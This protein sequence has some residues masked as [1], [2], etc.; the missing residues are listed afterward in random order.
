VPCG[1]QTSRHAGFGILRRDTAG[2]ARRRAGGADA[3]LVLADER[4][5]ALWRSSAFRRRFD[6]EY[7]RRLGHR[8]FEIVPDGVPRGEVMLVREV[9]PNGAALRAFALR[10]RA[11]AGFVPGED[12]TRAYAAAQV[13]QDAGTTRTSVRRALARARFDT[14]AGPVAFDADGYREPDTL[15]LAPP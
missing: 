14:V 6:A 5:P 10:F 7:V 13:L 11:A 1:G 8:D 2:A 12:A 15:A 9:P 4:P 3:V